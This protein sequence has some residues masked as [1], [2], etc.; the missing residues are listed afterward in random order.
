MPMTRQER[1]ALH[2]NQKR[3]QASNSMPSISEIT[4]G[5]PVFR[6]THKGLYQ[7]VKF[8]G[9]VYS[10][11]MTKHTRSLEEEINETVKNITIEEITLSGTLDV[12][13]G[14]TG[15]T[16][17]TDGA[18]MLGSGTSAITP[19]AVTTNG[20]ILIGDGSTD[21][22][23]YDAFSS[24]TGTLKVSAGGTGAA[25]LT[26]NAVLTGNGTSAIQAEADL[27]FASNVVYPTA[28]AHDT[29]G[30]AL[31]VSAGDTTAGT[32]NNIAGGALTF[33]GGIGKGSGAGGDII[34]KTANAGSSGS[35]LNSLATALTISDDLSASFTGSIDVDGTSNLDDV[36]ID[37]DV[38]IS[39]D[40]TLSAG[41]DGALQ[42]ASAGEN[43][44]RIPDGQSSALIIEEAGNAYM[45]FTTTNSGEKVTCNKHLYVGTIK[46]NGSV[47]SASGAG[48]EVRSDEDIDFIVRQDGG[49]AYADHPITFKDYDENF[50]QFFYNTNLAIIKTAT[51]ADNLEINS[52]AGDISF[53]KA[54]NA[55]GLIFD[56]DTAG[57]CYVE[58]GAGD[59]VVAIDDGDRRLYFFDKGDEYIVSDG[60]DLTIAAGTALNITAD[61]IDLSDAT[62]DVT[63]NS[64]V[65]ALNFDSNTLSI[66]ASNNRIGV[67]TAAPLTLVHLNAADP[68]LLVKDTETGA[69]SANARLRLAES[70]G[71]DVLG[72][73]WDI[74]HSGLNLLLTRSDGTG[75]V[76]IRSSYITDHAVT[77]K[78]A[79][80][81]RHFATGD[82]DYQQNYSWVG[83]YDQLA[84]ASEHDADFGDWS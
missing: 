49:G 65:D 69:A 74:H 52:Q 5:K 20:S 59:A 2:T 12:S 63:L 58:N 41:G 72:E 55:T 23:T 73:Y 82:A 13:S 79:T 22:T 17:I 16:T 38:D 70:G 54:A 42:F 61:I 37:G 45:T 40:L 77:S 14:G 68:V 80:N 31:T 64:A 35:S 36:D 18:V 62:K 11:L 67:G 15:L 66:D 28:T 75:N 39:G 50:L 60:T 56:L 84:L 29:A 44:I 27:L 4:E 78:P 21:P 24:S 51:A 6:E 25:S 26:S 10:Q 53:K 30:K 76:V 32:T 46:D 47:Y 8:R 83:L 34:F 43:S 9:E 19:L 7:Y 57:A 71:S 48:W 1:V 33:E 81:G 3:M